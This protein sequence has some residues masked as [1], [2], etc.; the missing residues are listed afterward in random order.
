VSSLS[1]MV[2]AVVRSFRL[3]SSPSLDAVMGFCS[4]PRRW[5]RA[6]KRPAR[7]LSFR[8]VER[9]ATR[10]SSAANDVFSFDPDIARRP[11]PS[12]SSRPPAATTMRCAKAASPTVPFTLEP[13]W[14]GA[15]GRHKGEAMRPHR[16]LVPGLFAGLDFGMLHR[17]L[18]TTR[19]AFGS[20]EPNRPQILV[21][22]MARADL[23]AVNVGAQRH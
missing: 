22:V 18:C 12:R 23:P 14:P 3:L 8:A 5:R 13:A 7:Q 20:A 4:R 17:R 6:I 19:S 1:Q 9:V 21:G 10:A 15:R 11:R 16:R 2:V